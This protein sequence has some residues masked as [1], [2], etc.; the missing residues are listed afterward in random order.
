VFGHHLMV[1]YRESDGLFTCSAMGFSCESARRGLEFVTRKLTHQV[2][3]IKCGLA[4]ELLTGNLGAK[5]DW[6][7]AGDYVGAMCT[8]LQQPE[9][10]DYVLAT[11]KTHSARELLEVAFV[12]EALDW[13]GYAEIEPNLIRPA[14]V[15]LLCGDATKAREKVG[16]RPEVGYEELIKMTAEADVE[17]VQRAENTFA[18]AA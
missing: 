8:M 1:N 13:K 5:R 18:N 2:T 16:W 7:F 11:G 12:T 3:R 14:E 6:G 10:D 15:D 4:Q 9:P 17:P